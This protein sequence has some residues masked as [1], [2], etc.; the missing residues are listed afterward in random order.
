MISNRSAGLLSGIALAGWLL[1]M[2]LPARP[3]I[4]WACPFCSAVAR[5]FS[6]Q[7]DGFDIVVVASLQSAPE[8]EDETRLPRARFQIVDF[9][10]GRETF[11]NEIPLDQ[12]FEAIVVSRNHEIGD[13]FL[14]MGNGTRQINWSTPMKV[15]NRVV[16]YLKQLDEL[17]EKGP[18]RLAYFA[19]FFE[20]HETVLANDAYDEFARASYEEV[21]AAAEHL[22]RE[23]LLGWLQDPEVMK[24][25]KRLY[26]TLLGVCGTADDVPFLEEVIRSGDR[27][28]Q[29]GLDALLACYLTLTGDDGVAVLEQTFLANPKAE[30][31]DVFSAIAALRFHGTEAEKVSRKRIVEALRHVLDRPRMAD[32]VIPDL[33]RWEDWSVMDRLVQMFKD[34]NSD[35]TK[36][37]RTPII[38]YLQACPADEAAQY[39]VELR[40]IDPE[41]VQRAE[42][43]AELD[44][45][46]D[47]SWEDEN[48]T[49][50]TP[51][52]EGPEKDDSPDPTPQAGDPGRG[53]GTADAPSDGQ[54]P[55]DLV[56]ALKPV[57][58]DPAGTADPDRQPANSPADV[59]SA[60]NRESA[61][62]VSTGR[63]GADASGTVAPP[64]EA[65]AQALQPTP[66]VA[67]V[68]PT[69]P[70]S[71][72]MI[73]IAFVTCVL[74]FALLW[75]VLNGW[76]ERLIF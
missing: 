31:I 18:E 3:V 57:V 38:S 7:M 29:S 53:G 4:A 60:V 64:P 45:E 16:D 71:A 49:D 13:H 67:V 65:S 25:R 39:I 24:S 58:P 52:A 17:P 30:Y 12:S 62:F 26:Y 6:E 23:K 11:E 75:S 70:S 19:Q 14:V 15:S 74:L 76:F 42:M 34:A 66:P 2:A 61:S 37:V 36:W 63:P 21:R 8:A 72:L 48:A 22:D 55:A 1:A 69:S 5:T 9:L 40:Q 20:D 41:A 68:S 28:R 59:P 56:V 54:L 73:V 32:M 43:L 44:W 33:A 10:K 27:D 35:D 46:D 50:A 51:A 47:T